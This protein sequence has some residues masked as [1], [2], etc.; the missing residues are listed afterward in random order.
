MKLIWT[1]GELG[2]GLRCYCAGEFFLAHEHWESVWLGSKEPERTFLQGLIQVAAA[3]H[4]LQRGNSRGTRSLLERARVRLERYPEYFWGM[5]VASLCQ[6]I[7]E[8]LQLLEAGSA[9]QHRSY[10]QLHHGGPPGVS[11]HRRSGTD[12]GQKR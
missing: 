1:E 11:G 7:G 8:W 10:P 4:H 9:T 5:D 6:E 3:F 2:E 12:G